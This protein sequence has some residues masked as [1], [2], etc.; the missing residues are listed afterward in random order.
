METRARALWERE[1]LF[2][3]RLE[4]PGRKFY[5]LMMFPYPSGHLHVGH[6]R[7]YI[8]GDALV[9][10][11]LMRG[12]R[13]LSP[14]GWDAFGLPA[15]NAAI[16]GGKH[17]RLSTL[18]NIARMKEQLQR[19]GCGYDWSREIASCHPGY[20]RWTQ[21]MFLQLYRAGLAYR[22]RAPV[23]WCPSCATVLANE[24]VLDGAC[25]RCGTMV[26]PRD[27]EQWFFRITAYAQRLLDDLRL[28]DRWPE[29]VL[30]MQRNWIGRS[31]G[32][33]L[34]FRI[35]PGEEVVRCFTTRPD[36]V[37][38]VTFV[39]MA[40][41]HPI[42]ERVC[43]GNPR[44]GAIRAFAGKARRQNFVERTSADS[45]KEGIDTG[46]KVRVPLSG[47]LVPLWV[48]NYV[49]P[50]Y[51]TG[52]V[53]GVPA[54]DERDF[55]FAKAHALPVRVVI[56][57]PDGIPPGGLAQAHVGEGRQVNSGPFD[58]L[59][60]SEGW[61]RIADAVEK[62]GV[63]RRR[64]T[65]RLRDWL[66]SRQRYWGAPIPIV[67]C[68][69]CGIVP[70]PEESLPIL[71]PPDVEFRPTGESPLARSPE[72]VETSCP[73]CGGKARRETDTM[74]TFV[75]SS[76][77]FLRYLSPRDTA[78]PFDR[79]L[80]DA[81]LP[82][83]QYI[84]GVEHAILHL[85]YARFFTKV[86][87]DLGHVGFDEPF[88]ALFT[89][90]LITKVAYQC[91]EHGWLPAGP[92]LEARVAGGTRTCPEPRHERFE[93]PPELRVSLHKMSK[94]K[95]NTVPPEPLIERFGADAVRLYT[96]FVGPPEKEAE[97]DDASVVGQY[98]FLA[99]FHDL[100]RSLAPVPAGGDPKGAKGAFDDLR[101]A[102]H[103]ALRSVS[104]AFEGDFHFNTA[105]ATL[106]TL[107]DRIGKAAPAAEAPAD[108]A[109]LREAALL[110]VRMLAPFA[111]HLAEELWSSMGEKGSVFRRAWPAY[112]PALAK[113]REVEIALQVNGKVRSRLVVPSDAA[114]EEI[115]SRALADERV[116][117]WTA[118][119]P[120]AKTV[121][122][123]GRLVNFV[124]R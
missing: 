44:A 43:A 33:E 25:E 12:D 77:Y 16:Q 98:R 107:A 59:P 82:V 60:N 45:P 14:M 1:D 55:A 123:P 52:A 124:L 37:F 61:E 38:G 86:L 117:E 17:P 46:V 20:Y 26:E 97:W 115:R 75:D 3:A 103:S 40:P 114:E 57:P 65:F 68:A 36:T 15:E 90:G 63:G 50:E 101:R 58:G 116:R 10:Y 31:E 51:G 79:A 54:H 70:V 9:R 62:E 29:R 11:R 27:L 8:L 7:N 78:R 93:A 105:I 120:I 24:Q 71:L 95:G 4:G 121:V 22:K 23:N 19:W 89:Q 122:V 64:V 28:L 113:S 118:G 21:W 108:R 110:A 80:L 13:V 96:L 99:R 100:V 2:R 73:K 119:R 88:G 42:L 106:H 87:H 85:L 111:P 84:G 94:S 92:S 6:G 47:E 76:W 91:P 74:D 69:A 83:D 72:F 53:M 18:A 30:A 48:V 49:L 109:A 34:D 67:T 81:W 5:A 102:A 56:E 35:S 112:D 104:E 41:E 66:I 32:V 39:A